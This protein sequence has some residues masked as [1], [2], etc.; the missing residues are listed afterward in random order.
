MPNFGLFIAIAIH[1]LWHSMRTS[2]LSLYIQFANE[3]I[4]G[5]MSSVLI[6]FL[7]SLYHSHSDEN[8]TRQI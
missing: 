2:A 1:V 4:S 7:Q 8:F 3:I 5:G 6:I